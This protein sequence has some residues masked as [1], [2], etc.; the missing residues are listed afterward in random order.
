LP[1][2]DLFD[3]RVKRLV[4][5]DGHVP[6]EVGVVADAVEGV[7]FAEEGLPAPGQQRLQHLLLRLHR[8]AGPL[9]LPARYPRRQRLAQY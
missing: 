9:R 7:V 3:V 4:F 2:D 8:L 5:P 1:A 6:A